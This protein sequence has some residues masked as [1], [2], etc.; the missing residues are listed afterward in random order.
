M[1]TGIYDI[2]TALIGNKFGHKGLVTRMD[3]VEIKTE[4]HDRKL[5]VW[6]SILTA[7]G[8]ALVFLKDILHS[9]PKQ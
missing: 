2:K 8:T 1:E 3:D 5:L 9:N 6:G 4:K 7:A